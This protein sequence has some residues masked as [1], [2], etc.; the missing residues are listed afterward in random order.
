MSEKKEKLRR[1]WSI[2]E[3]EQAKNEIDLFP[4]RIILREMFP[5]IDLIL[6]IKYDETGAGPIIR[7]YSDENLVEHCGIFSTAMKKVLIT[8][9]CIVI[10]N[11]E[12]GQFRLEGGLYFQCYTFDKFDT[13]GQTFYIG[14][15]TYQN[16]KWSVTPRKE[17][18]VWT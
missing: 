14:N 16:G 2:E 18:E 8:M 5:G 15:T 13:R 1:C 3:L 17:M 9:S 6:K 7:I 10:Q 12:T 11:T 4:L